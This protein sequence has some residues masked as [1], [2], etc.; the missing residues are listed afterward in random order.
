MGFRLLARSSWY[1]RMANQ[2][3]P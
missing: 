3:M 2:V 1:Q